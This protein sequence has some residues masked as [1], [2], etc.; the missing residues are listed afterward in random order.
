M[1]ILISY[2]LFYLG[3]SV[4]AHVVM[5]FEIQ[6][7]DHWRSQYF[8]GFLNGNVWGSALKMKG[9]SALW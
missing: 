3:F 5:Y 8:Q 1:I 4:Y 6:D 7:K 9:S 2:L